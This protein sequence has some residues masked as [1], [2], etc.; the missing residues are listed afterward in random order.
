MFVRRTELCNA[1]VKKCK[2]H[3]VRLS[4]IDLFHHQ[5]AFALLRLGGKAVA[6]VF[7]DLVL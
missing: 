1:L 6:E 5:R 4:V 7:N 3:R 2:A